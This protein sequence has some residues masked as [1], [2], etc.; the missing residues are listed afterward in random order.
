[1]KMPS[2]LSKL[3]KSLKTSNPKPVPAVD[4]LPDTTVP[5]VVPSSGIVFASDFMPD[6]KFENTFCI[7]NQT[8][9][10]NGLRTMT[11]E[12][13]T[14]AIRY[15]V[16]NGYTMAHVCPA[17]DGPGYEGALVRKWLEKIRAAGLQVCLWFDGGNNKFG[18]RDWNEARFN[19]VIQRAV[20]ICD[21][22]VDV[23]CIGIEV[24]E[25]RWG[26]DRVAR[27]VKFAQ[28][29]AKKP[30]AVHTG[31]RLPE[32]FAAADVAFL[33][34]GFGTNTADISAYTRQIMAMGK[35]VVAMEYHRD[36][37]TAAAKAMG[38]A[39]M[40][41]GAIGFGNGGTVE[42]TKLARERAL[43][44]LVPAPVP[45]PVPSTGYDGSAQGF[46]KGSRLPLLGTLPVRNILRGA[47]IE[48][49]MLTLDYDGQP[50][51][52][53]AM[54]VAAWQE[55]DGRWF[56]CPFEW[57]LNGN[58]RHEWV[59]NLYPKSAD[60]R[61]ICEEPGTRKVHFPPSGAAVWCGLGRCDGKNARTVSEISNLILA[62][63]AS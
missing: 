41:A 11:D 52:A 27:H 30:V 35:K 28:Q 39:A 54:F 42:A 24:D 21:D 34:Y 62:G 16:S 15:L 53:A 45:S 14:A 8:A 23:Y 59:S 50:F 19:E 26:A 12:M 47:R 9:R 17:I 13:R 1:M 40:K 49:K 51:G 37:A 3:L 60:E 36:G 57:C 44:D 38:E 46:Y 29:L 61:G 56:W 4:P 32:Y 33:Q 18:Q 43:V 31:G 10:S 7:A 63:R 25:Y 55:A 5:P 58:K 22:L 20:T 2:W 6:Q 48:G